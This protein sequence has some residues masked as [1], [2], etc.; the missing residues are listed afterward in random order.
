MP[1]R[2]GEDVEVK[3]SSLPGRAGA[4]G[5]ELPKLRYGPFEAPMRKH[6]VFSAPGY[7]SLVDAP[8][9]ISAFDEFTFKGRQGRPIRVLVHGDPQDHSQHHSA[10]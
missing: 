8:V 10:V 2:R 9:E 1:D 5:V 6:P 3:F 4:L 7:D